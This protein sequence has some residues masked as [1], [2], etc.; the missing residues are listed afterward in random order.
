MKI[1]ISFLLATVSVGLGNLL[2]AGSL[3]RSGNP[4]TLQAGPGFKTNIPVTRSSTPKISLQAS[5][6]GSPSAPIKAPVASGSVLEGECQYNDVNCIDAKRYQYC[7]IA[8]F[9]CKICHA[10]CTPIATWS[11]PQAIAPGGECAPAAIKAV[12]NGRDKR[13]ANSTVTTDGPQVGKCPMPGHHNCVGGMAVQV[14]SDDLDWSAPKPVPGGTRC[15]PMGQA[16]TLE[17]IPHAAP[18]NASRSTAPPV[19]QSIA[20]EESVGF[21]TCEYR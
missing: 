10:K 12:P 7:K 3:T 17:L 14:C 19:P 2:N 20:A 8:S 21:V 16:H 15:S 1:S 4:A 18:T 9:N 13:A 6:R 5:S 11:D